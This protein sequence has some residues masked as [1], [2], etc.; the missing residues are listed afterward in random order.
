MPGFTPA[1]ASVSP[2]W[3]LASGAVSLAGRLASPTAAAIA[4]DRPGDCAT[5][6]ASGTAATENAKAMNVLRML[7]SPDIR[8]SPRAEDERDAAKCHTVVRRAGGTGDQRPRHRHFTLLIMN[9]C[10]AMPCRSNQRRGPQE[11]DTQRTR[12]D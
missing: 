1:K 9:I 12:R 6:I 8:S 7:F 5:T 10:A 11:H 3:R 4:G 2:G